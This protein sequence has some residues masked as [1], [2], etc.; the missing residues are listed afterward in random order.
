MTSHSR[1]IIQKLAASHRRYSEVP[2][3]MRLLCQKNRP[4]T[5]NGDVLYVPTWARWVAVDKN[6]CAFA[7]ENRPSPAGA[8]WEASKGGAFALV[9][10][11]EIAENSCREWLNTLQEIPVG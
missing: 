5:Y 2:S 7:Y 4:V 6:G 8:E 11:F 9:A 3:R 1:S 10:E